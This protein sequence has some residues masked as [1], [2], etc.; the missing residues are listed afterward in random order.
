MKTLLLLLVCATVTAQDF[1][2]ENNNLIWQNVIESK[3]S[4][5][6]IANASHKRFV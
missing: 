1:K 4:R 5:T 6:E 2:I 3:Q